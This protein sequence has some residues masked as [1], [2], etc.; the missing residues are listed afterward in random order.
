MVRPIAVRELPRAGARVEAS[1]LTGVLVTVPIVVLVEWWRSAA[2]TGAAPP[3]APAPRD[4]Q[5]PI[6]QLGAA[7]RRSCTSIDLRGKP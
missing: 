3:A 6:L 1:T 5:R 4:E 2:S 7:N